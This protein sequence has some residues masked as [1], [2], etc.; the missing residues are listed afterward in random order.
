MYP[1]VKEMVDEMCEDAKNDM[2]RMDQ[3]ELGSWSHAIRSADG[4]WMTHGYHSKNATFSI[5]NYN[6]GALP[7]RKHLC[8]RGRDNVLK[9]ELYQG[10]SLQGCRRVCCMPDFQKSTTRWDEHSHSVAGC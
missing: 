1:V 4:T 2:R 3:C 6:N 10:T 9:E 5:R 8:Q 7:Y